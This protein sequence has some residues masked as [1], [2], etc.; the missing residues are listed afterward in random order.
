[1][2][3]LIIIFAQ[4][5][6]EMADIKKER[7]ELIEMFGVHFESLYNLPPLGARIL[8]TLIVV[9]KEQGMTFEGL[10]EYMGASKS[11]VSTNLN[12]MLKMGKITYF[13][14]PGDRKKY[15]KASPFSKTFEG[16]LKM[17]DYE[18]N[19][20]EKLIAYRQEMVT[21]TQEKFNFEYIMAYKE[22]VLEMESI[23][24]RTIE[25]FREIEKN[26]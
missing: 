10:V 7:E 22:H 6:E 23:L 9:H 5:F 24:E 26:I 13:T 25:R 15:F 1:V 19:I 21:I 8:G 4:N 2:T 11:S 12:L 16:Y 3:E 17:I 20:I 18:K 14:L